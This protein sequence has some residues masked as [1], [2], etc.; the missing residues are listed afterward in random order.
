MGKKSPDRPEST[1]G[2]IKTIGDVCEDAARALIDLDGAL[3]AARCLV[4]LTIADGGASEGPVLYKRL[5]ALEYILRQAGSAEDTLWVAVDKMSLA[6]DD[7]EPA[8]F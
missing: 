2:P 5:N 7:Q 8:P 3:T 6:L 1:Q 4:D